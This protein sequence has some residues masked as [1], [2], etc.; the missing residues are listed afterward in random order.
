MKA[1]TM[2]T[3]RRGEDEA[4]L[5][6]IEQN[7]TI[8]E[9][10]WRNSHLEIDII[11]LTG[12]ELHIVEVK[13]RVAPLAA[14]PL[15]NITPKKMERLT[16]AALAYLHSPSARHLSGDMEIC[17]DVITVVFDGGAAAIE[18]YPKAYIPIYV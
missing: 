11:T 2:K 15:A 9:R 7:H 5:Y 1:S 16:R 6:L 14:D 4:C 13:S 17:F 18:Y 8:L 10:N 12:N 3:G